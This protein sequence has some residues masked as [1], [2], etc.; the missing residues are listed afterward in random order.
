MWLC[1][2]QHLSLCVSRLLAT[3]H[4]NCRSDLCENFTRDETTDREE[5]ITFWK[6][7][8]SRSGS[9]NFLKCSSALSDGAFFHNLAHIS[10]KTDWI[11]M[12]TLSGMY[13]WRRK[14]LL[15]FGSHSES[16][17]G[18]RIWT[19]FALT[20]SVLSACHCLVLMQWIYVCRETAWGSGTERCTDQKVK[21]ILCT[22]VTFFRLFLALED[23]K[24]VETVFFN[25][26]SASSLDSSLF[27]T[28]DNFV[29]VDCQENLSS[30]YTALCY[31]SGRDDGGGDLTAGGMTELSRV[32]MDIFRTVAS[33]HGLFGF[34]QSK[35]FVK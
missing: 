32:L 22:F 23:S 30:E 19:G 8:A 27:Q 26:H 31:V 2:S 29:R 25:W 18:L 3:L 21:K 28:F 13:I 24:L 17:S 33:A 34:F 12:K 15:H 4:K 10:G 20:V 6:W 5:W 7:S 9:G 16:C 35:V 14:S 11:F 1:F